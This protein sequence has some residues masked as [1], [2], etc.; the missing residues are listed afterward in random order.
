MSIS[1]LNPSPSE[2]AHVLP[3][4]LRFLTD[5]TRRQIHYFRIDAS[6]PY[7]KIWVDDLI[8]LDQ[9]RESDQEREGKPLGL[10]RQEEVLGQRQWGGIGKTG[11]GGRRGLEVWGL[12]GWFL[13][14]LAW[15]V[16]WVEQP[17]AATD[18]EG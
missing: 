4:P 14:K 2:V 11:I 13:N 17:H 1:S 5:P 9:D 16:G 3:L 18:P 6:K 8:P 10:K 7:Y 12:S 15:K